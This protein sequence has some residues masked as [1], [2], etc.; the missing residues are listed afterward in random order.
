MRLSELVLEGFK[1]YTHKTVVGPLDPAFNAITGLNGTGKSNIFDGLCFVMGFRPGEQ[2]RVQSMEE[3]IHKRGQAGVT[4]A[5]VT[6]VLDNSDP[7]LSPPMYQGCKTITVTRQIS[8]GGRDRFFINGHPRK[9]NEVQK[10]FQEARL[11]PLRPHFIVMQ[12][13]VTKIINMKPKELLEYFQDAVGTKLFDEQRM[14]SQKTLA[15]KEAKVG[16]NTPAL[17]AHSEG[18]Y[19]Q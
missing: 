15:E 4:S 9:M 17:I 2:L 12:G 11:N 6:A 14:R 13:R 16:C 5:A 19:A 3:L 18:P 8:V 10:L 1:S 7:L